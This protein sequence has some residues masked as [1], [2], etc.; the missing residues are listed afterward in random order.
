MIRVLQISKLYHPTIGGVESIVQSIAEGLKSRLQMQVLVCMPKGKK[1]CEE[2]NGVTVTRSSSLGIKHSMPV[3]LTFPFDLWRLSCEKDILHF[4][5]PFPLGDLAYLLVRPKVKVVVWWHSEIIRQKFFLKLYALFMHMFLR[6][7]DKIIVA[8][9]KH[10]EETL[11]LHK[12]LDKCEVIPFGIDVKKYTL[13][14]PLSNA[15]DIIRAKYG[16]R[17]ALFVG[18]LVYYKGIE[19]LIQAMKDVDCHLII[20]GEGNLED[21]LKKMVADLG[22]EDRVFFIGKVDDEVLPV[23]FNACDV[24]MFP[25]VARTEAFGIVQLEAMACGKPVINTNLPTGVPWVSKDGET[26]LT[27]PTCDSGALA[28]AMNILFHNEELRIGYGK[29]ALSR[30]ND[31]FNKDKMLDSVYELYAKLIQ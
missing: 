26:G 5:M 9:P 4:H 7:A 21:K 31:C 30:V 14:E 10:L 15:V 8:T 13:N 1:E 27:V 11:I 6:K 25:S 24:F 3:S 22:I 2:I 28:K 23:Y 16:S 20:I 17:I 18:R 12:Y 19:Y 29:N